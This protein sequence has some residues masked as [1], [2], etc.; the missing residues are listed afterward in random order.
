MALTLIRS[1]TTLT[2]VLNVNYNRFVKNV[3]ASLRDG[4]CATARILRIIARGLY[5]PMVRCDLWRMFGIGG[6]I[7]NE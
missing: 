2:T 7:D 5:F 3:V 4:M 6:V 1:L